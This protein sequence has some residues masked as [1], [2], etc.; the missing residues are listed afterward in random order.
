MLDPSAHHSEPFGEALSHSSQRA[1]Q[2]VSLVAAA[3]EVA[4]RRRALHTARQAAR[5]EQELRR[6]QQD[7]SAFLAQV[8][9]QWAPA[10]DARWLAQADL[11]Q[12]GRAWGAA[13]PWADAYIEAA[14]A[15]NR[16]EERL[17]ALHPYAMTQYDRLRSEGAHPVDAMRR[18][19]HLFL[20]EPHPRPGQSAPAR[21]PIQAGLPGVGPAS[22]P[23]DATSSPDQPTSA[24]D[25]YQEA[26]QRGRGIAERLQARALRERGTELSADEL[27][28]ALE[29]STS[30]PA[31]V[32]SRLVRAEAEERLAAAAERARAADL[33]HAAAA[34]SAPVRAGDLKAARRDT[35]AADTA[36]AYA[37]ADRSAARLAA[38]SFPYTAADGIRAAA[39][40][41]LQPTQ[42]ADRTPAVQNTRR[43]TVSP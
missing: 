13:A 38:E 37:S 15:L 16:A 30:L 39:T 34:S 17:R 11:L 4:L 41:R 25:P 19:V 24:Q 27:A 1:A 21:T 5:D 42:A 20:R 43:M 23:D 14:A 35:L 32:I 31:E 28:T 26:E 2:M 6:V 18:S 29:A 40:G 22:G 36:S 12:A 7:E 9:A 10:L 33:G 3:A 8:R